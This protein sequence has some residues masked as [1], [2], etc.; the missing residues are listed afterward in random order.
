MKL[1]LNTKKQKL[2]VIP[3][4]DD[5]KDV[6]ATHLELSILLSRT[7]ACLA[8]SSYDSFKTKRAY[9]RNLFNVSML[10]LEELDGDTMDARDRLISL[11]CQGNY[12]GNEDD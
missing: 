6:E 4:E 12:F 9:I 2:K 11:I 7:I 10:C 8:D 3:H 5:D 1:I